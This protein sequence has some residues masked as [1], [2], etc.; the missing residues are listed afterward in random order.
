MTKDGL[1]WRLKMTEQER[2]IVTKYDLLFEQ[3]ITRVET[4]NDS[5]K[6]NLDGLK[7]DVREIR[8]DIRWIINIMFTGFGSMLGLMLGM[9]GIM[10][11]GFKWI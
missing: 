7:Q 4:N 10:A 3:R 2:L 5:F 11:H 6:E 8:Q 9:L 1:T